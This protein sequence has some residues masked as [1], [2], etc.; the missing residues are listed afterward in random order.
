MNNRF[1]LR[2]IFLIFI[3]FLLII[4]ISFCGKAPLGDAE[5][6]PVLPHLSPDY[7][8]V[9]IPPNIAPM[10]FMIQEPVEQYYVK[11]SSEKGK[12]IILSD[13]K[14]KVIIPARAWKRLLK[15]NR[16]NDLRIEIAIRDQAGTWSRFPTIIN[17]IAAEEIDSYLAY[18]LIT[19]AYNNWR[20]MGIFQR[21]LETFRERPFLLNRVT[22]NNCMNC[23]NFCGND[24]DNMIFHMRGGRASGMM[25]LHDGKL[26][27]VNTATD[28][29]KAGAYPSWHPNKNLLALS[30]NSLILFFHAVGESR[31]VLDMG[32]DI[33]VYNISK[34]M[35]TTSPKIADKEY[36]ETFPCWSPEGDYL[37]F[38]RTNP[39]DDF[40][41]EDKSDLKWDQIRYNLMRVSYDAAGDN[42]GEVELLVPAAAAKKS[43]TMP[44]VSPD[45]KYLLFCLSDYSNFPIYLNSADLYLMNLANRKFTRLPVNSEL[46]ETFHSW[47]SNSRWFVFSSKRGDGMCARPYFSYLDSLGN[48][49]KPFV[50][51]QKDP[52]FYQTY[53]M[54][55]NVPEMMIKPFPVNWREITKAAFDSKRLIK[56]QLDPKV[57]S[58]IAAKPKEAKPEEKW[59][60]APQ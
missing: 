23:H 30:V 54:T 17:P 45:G 29:N 39:L 10:N 42:W 5:V 13:N 8:G 55:Y 53:L 32:S 51:P 58:Q 57:K 48:A 24:P 19:P 16:G 7:I 18:R 28:F 59:H 21:N 41:L 20:I 38:C 14:P 44:R 27:K 26:A 11:I 25:L 1:S 33:V 15:A 56:A 34:N 22:E 4:G 52:E 9:V 12:A 43:V 46:E 6:L 49:H 31:D 35:I 60:P 47:S 50:L 40:M 37:Y 2:S 36:M 3:I